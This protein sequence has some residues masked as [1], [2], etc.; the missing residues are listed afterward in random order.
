MRQAPPVQVARALEARLLPLAIAVGAVTGGTGAVPGT[1]RAVPGGL[2]ADKPG[3]AL[4][5]PSRARLEA[6]YALEAPR[7]ALALGALSDLLGEREGADAGRLTAALWLAAELA[8]EELDRWGAA[9]IASSPTEIASSP[10]EIASSAAEIASSNHAGSAPAPPPSRLP[11]PPPPPPPPRW[12]DVQPFLGGQ[13]RLSTMSERRLADL[14][15]PCH[16][17]LLVLCA[18]LDATRPLLPSMQA[19]T[20]AP[21]DATDENDEG[22]HDKGRELCPSLTTTLPGLATLTT[23]LTA[24]PPPVT[25]LLPRAAA[26]TLA[27]NVRLGPSAVLG[28]VVGKKDK[29]GAV[30]GALGARSQGG[31]VMGAGGGS[32]GG[33]DGASA[34]GG[35]AADWTPHQLQRVFQEME[36]RVRAASQT[37][38]GSKASG[39]KMADLSPQLAWHLAAIRL[40]YGLQPAGRAAA[41]PP[42]TPSL[43]GAVRGDS[44]DQPAPVRAYRD[45]A[46]WVVGGLF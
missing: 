20:T 45:L 16:H 24:P 19:L 35:I 27:A 39:G 40:Q 30:V 42:P 17:F 3:T 15:E 7:H 31:A 9:E 36:R 41:L 1:F 23:T 10:V 32:G 29:E 46:T 43:T 28:S 5:A 12:D 38:D 33:C 14:F 25:A 22:V 44:L 4:E 2:H 8:T 6:Q 21:P 37:L 11:P 13:A 26:V 34:S 18:W